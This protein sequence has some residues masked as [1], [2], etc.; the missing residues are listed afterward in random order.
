L[1]KTM[2]P[3]APACA[4]A[5]AFSLKL[6]PPRLTTAMLPSNMAALRS[7]LQ[8]LGG[9]ARTNGAATGNTADVGEAAYVAERVAAAVMVV[10]LQGWLLLKKSG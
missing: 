9:S 2:T 1:F 10:V 4:A 7:R 5:I 6:Q 8:A 3:Y